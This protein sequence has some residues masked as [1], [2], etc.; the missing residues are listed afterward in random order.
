[1]MALQLAREFD[2]FLSRKISYAKAD[3]YGYLTSSLA[4]VG[5]GFRLSVMLHLVG[6][7]YLGEVLPVLTAASELKV[8]I[9]GMLGEGTRALGDV[10]QVSNE[11]TIGFTEREIASRIRAVAEHLISREREA[12]RR[13]AVER[14]GELKEKVQHAWAQ[15]VEARALTGE[16]AISYLSTLRLGHAIG[17]HPGISVKEFS[18]LLVSMKLV[19]YALDGY[20]AVPHMVGTSD[21]VR[22]AKLIR[23]KLLKDDSGSK[24]TLH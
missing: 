16:D 14:S 3:N 23:D 7:A 9:R 10:F 20:A 2:S 11:T 24:M 21:D 1:M 4:N 19:P 6:L 17:L 5:T 22:R 12:R 15:L 13:L 8:S 18:E